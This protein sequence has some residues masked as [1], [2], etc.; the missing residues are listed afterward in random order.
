[1]LL[2][3]A[4]LNTNLIVKK[5]QGE[6]VDKLRLMDLGLNVGTNVLVKHKSILKNNLLLN[7]NNSCFVIGADIAKYIEV[8]YA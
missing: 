7:F 1:M 4:K 3:D 8:N 6:E 2:I 5:I